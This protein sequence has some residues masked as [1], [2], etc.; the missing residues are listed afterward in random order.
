MKKTWVWDLETL[1]V[2]TAT[3]VD[4]DSDETKVFVLTNTLNQLPELLDFLNNEVAGLIGYNSIFFDAQIIEYIYRYPNCKA[5]DIRNYAQIITANNNRK[6]DVPEWSLRHK[7]LDL[8]KALSLST[9]A[10]RTGLKWCEYQMDYHNIEDIPSQGDGNNW[11]EQVLSYNLN[12]VLATKTLYYKYKHEIDLRL[13]IGKRENVHLLNSTEPDMAKK[14]F[15]KH[16]SKAMDIPEN[17]LKTLYT[18]RPIVKVNDII[19]P[20]IEFKTPLF[21]EVLKAFKRTELVE[22]QQFD[23]TI[24]YSNIDI[25]FGLGGI[26]GSIS[27]SVVE[28]NDTH[29]IKTCD[30]VSFYPNLA[31]K[32]KW[33]PAH[34][35]TNKF[36]S[37]YEGYFIERK[38]IPKSDPKNY[39]LKILLNSAY[40]LT[41]DKY[42]FLRDRQ[43]TL[44][45]CIN[46]QLL[47]AMLFENIIETI[48][49]SKLL[50]CNT[51]GFEVLIPR[52]YEQT[53]F[54][55]CKKWEE[56]TQLELEY[57]NY[58][59][60]ISSDVNNYISL[61][62][63]GKTKCK[64]KYEFKDIPLYKNKSF[65]IIPIAVYQYWVNNIPVEQI[66]KNHTNI[67]DFCAGVKSKKSDIK[68]SS[69][70]ELHNIVDNNLHKQKLSKTVRY[71]I[72]NSG[73]T[74]MKV[75]EDKSIAHV[76]APLKHKS[77]KKHWKVTYF[78]KYYDLPI[79]EYDIDYSYYIYHAKQ[80]IEQIQSKEQ[81]TLF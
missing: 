41:N 9:K 12:D 58:K 19:I 16:L 77:F 1:N 63:N 3:F 34:L 31:I 33:C 8:F 45:I 59:K 30:V 36:L 6:P 80:W 23:F 53:Y 62:E 2:F 20:Y 76:N 5:D 15:S 68:G 42:S 55:L 26:H 11:L 25:V 64:G 61:Y 78:N 38:S 70:Y 66:I 75:Y 81:L 7:H 73:S 79:N 57:D 29:I 50:V 72:S 28:S 17:V 32:N 13:D 74:L 56:L 43:V 69:H 18:E 65:N 51:D 54:D 48:P 14:L 10:K 4:K 37:L 21:N 49:D 60:I 22:N 27:N 46:G 44:S 52:E 24:N 71:F 47:L 39:I 67:F 35:P 40:G